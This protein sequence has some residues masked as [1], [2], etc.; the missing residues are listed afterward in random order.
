[1]GLHIILQSSRYVEHSNAYQLLVT[2]KIYTPY[3]AL[4]ECKS[5]LFEHKII[6]AGYLKFSCCAKLSY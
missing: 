3:R 6:G 2:P 4:V 1:M 5:T